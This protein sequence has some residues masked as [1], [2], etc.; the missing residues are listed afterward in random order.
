MITDQPMAQTFVAAHLF[1]N[2]PSHAYT[3]VAKVGTLTIYDLA[4]LKP[5]KQ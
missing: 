5:R 3:P 2:T 1:L 4:L